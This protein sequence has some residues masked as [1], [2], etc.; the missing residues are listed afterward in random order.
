MDIVRYPSESA[1][2]EAVKMDSPLI[3]AVSF[4]GG[5]AV[6]APL[7]EVGEHSIMLACADSQLRDIDSC[8][9][10]LFDT[11]SASWSFVCPRVYKGISERQEALRSFYQDGLSIIPEF[12]TLMG[13]FT[14]IKIKNLTGEIWDF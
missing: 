5:C 13:Y 3:A 14:Q 12:L 7:E 6:V 11:Q 8:F 4:D 1:V 10:L 2:N 9:R